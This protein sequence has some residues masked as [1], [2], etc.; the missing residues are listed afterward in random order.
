MSLSTSALSSPV[1]AYNEWDPLEEV[2]VGSAL[3]ARLPY[4][5]GGMNRLEPPTRAILPSITDRRYP[6]WIIRETEEDID[7]FIRVLDDLNIVVKRPQ[8]IECDA[9]L[10]TPFW[11]SDY[12][13]QYPPRDIMLVVGD[14]MIESP[15]PFR[16]RQYEIL[17]YREL[18]V[19]YLKRGA[20][21]VAAPKPALRDEL[22]TVDAEGEPALTE[23]EPAFDAA[24]VLRMGRDLIYLVSCS[25]NRVGAQWLQQAVGSQYRVHACDNLYKGTHIDTT[26]ALLKPG[27]ALANPERINAA[28]L[29][30]PI[31]D[32]Q[33]IYT[34]D[35]VETSYSPYE[36][37]SS[38]WIG[39]NLLML[40]PELAVV[41]ADQPA[42]IALLKQHGIESIPMR[43]RHGR[44]LA[45]GF[46]CITVDVRRSGGLEQY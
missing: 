37:I 14:Q 5:D 7:R 35:M 10:T 21:W 13:F 39:M 19:D 43:L 23:I 15:C 26:L 11:E 25:G 8:P 38:K 12:Y 17:A 32:W 29:P 28:N 34:P 22:Y 41:D 31:R 3:Y 9:M 1:S 30:A 42:L 27:L 44:L 18:M 46:H 20:R 40:N 16:S 24:N 4:H 36:G 2:I 6:E 45:G 33:I